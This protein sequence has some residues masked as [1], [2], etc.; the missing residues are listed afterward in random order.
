MTYFQRN[1]QRTPQWNP[2]RRNGHTDSGV[3]VVHTFEAPAGRTCTWGANFLRTRTDYGSY[4]WLADALGYTLHLAPWSAETWHETTVNN[5]AVGIS[6]MAYAANWRKITP[7]QRRNLIRGAALGAHRY[8]RWRV[9]QGKSAV[10]ARRISR[11]QALARVPG[12]IGHGEIDT[13]R[14]YDPG[15]HFPW[16]DFLAEYAR[17]ES[18]AQM[19]VKPTTPSTPSTGRTWLDMASEQDVKR[20]VDGAVENLHKA[21]V[22]DF[23]RNGRLT[24]NIWTSSHPT[25]MT[26][27]DFRGFLV[28]TYRKLAEVEAAQ[29][30]LI[31][32]IAALGRGEPFDEAKLLEGV[33]KAAQQGVAEAVDSIDTTVTINRED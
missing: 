2:R 13:G 17:L 7:T 28:S 15:P 4:H 1:S 32:A 6:M 3:V 20:V 8:S 26:T 12:F 29:A 25:Q 23:A 33:R 22:N 5:W 24:N 10:P 16:A 14:R 21:L 19:E 9:S 11:A 30:G 31:G 27:T 18:G